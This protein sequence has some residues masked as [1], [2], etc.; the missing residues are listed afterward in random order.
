M[1]LCTIEI[2]PASYG[3]C[4]LV[5]CG[6]EG[7][8]KSTNILIDTGFKQ[9][10]DRFLK[11]RLQE[12]H[13]DGERLALFVITH[14]D[15]D[16]LAGGLKFLKE[17]GHKNSPNVIEIENVWHN[18]FRHIQ[19]EKKIKTGLNERQKEVLDSIVVRGFPSTQK[20]DQ[21]DYEDPI[22]AEQGSS[23]ASLILEGEYPWNKEFQ[24]QAVISGVHDRVLINDEV[25]LVL[26]SPDEN[27]LDLLRKAW[28]R[29]L[30]KMG[31]PGK[32]SADKLFDDAFEFLI[33]REKRR[34]KFDVEKK[35][36]FSLEDMESLLTKPF[37]E[38]DSVS[39][40]SSIAFVFEFKDK[41]F[42]FLGD[43]HPSLIEANLRK[44]YPQSSCLYFDA[45]K[46]S[47]HGSSGN[48]S[49]GLLELID[50]EKYVISTNGKSNSH[51][52][53]METLLRIVS[54]ETGTKRDIFFNYPTESASRL[55]ELRSKKNWKYSVNISGGAEVTVLRF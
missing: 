15:A 8:K 51:H 9:T 6:G 29:E 16:H 44:L 3:D 48:T 12:L 37:K 53:D 21:F 19:L 39:N 36:S 52:P 32:I 55:E 31:F 50:S 45:V 20:E 43:S 14:I 10:Y 42:L 22:G 35:I 47:H 5:R 13:K 27:K 23:L 7:G 11:N 18:S 40:G 1:S 38:D 49:P 25:G 34:K 54:R 30:N 28:E 24:R 17:N 4:F 41:K 26:L 33:A 2:F 46:V